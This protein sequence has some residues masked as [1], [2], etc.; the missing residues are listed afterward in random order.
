MRPIPP[1]DPCSTDVVEL[2]GAAQEEKNLSAEMGFKV[3][4]INGQEQTSS[5]QRVGILLPCRVSNEFEEMI[6]VPEEDVRHVL[7]VQPSTGSVG[8]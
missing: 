4:S 8:Q 3:F 2:L 1:S 7:T 6:V 5:G